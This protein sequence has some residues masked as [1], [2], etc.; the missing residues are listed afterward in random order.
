MPRLPAR[1]TSGRGPDDRFGSPRWI[2]R[3]RR[4]RIGGIAVDSG[5][6]FVEF[7]LQTGDLLTGFVQLPE[8]FVQLP[9]S[10]VQLP[11]SFVQSSLELAAL[12]VCLQKPYAVD[13]LRG[14]LYRNRSR[15][16]A[17]VSRRSIN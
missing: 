6:Q 17:P 3:R 10:F 4:G 13:R 11:E 1:L 12:R 9:E 15:Y 14:R 5:V 7:R 2:D 16:F 8:S